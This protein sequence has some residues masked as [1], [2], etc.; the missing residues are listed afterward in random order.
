M[1]KLK[2]LLRGLGL[3]LVVAIGA[4][5][6]IPIIGWLATAVVSALALGGVALTRFG[7]RAYTPTSGVTTPPALPQGGPA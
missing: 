5:D 2:S 7:T 1:N 6:L 4:I 3:L